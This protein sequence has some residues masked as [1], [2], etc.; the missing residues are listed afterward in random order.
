MFGTIRI[1][2]KIFNKILTEAINNKFVDTSAVCVDSTH[3]KTCA[4]KKKKQELFVKNETKNYQKTLEKEIN[5][6]RKLNGKKEFNDKDDHDL[7]KI[8]KSKTDPDAG[9]FHKGEHEKQ[10]AYSAHTA[11][12]KKGFV[13]ARIVT[14]ANRYDSSVFKY[15][16]FEYNSYYDYFTCPN[17][18]VL[19]YTT[20]AD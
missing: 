8:T 18:N 6:D 1:I 16:D 7:H 11:C 2:Q 4:N 10:F 20:P 14:P 9:E 13:L 5:E 3:I 12:N 19:E 17:G 15:H